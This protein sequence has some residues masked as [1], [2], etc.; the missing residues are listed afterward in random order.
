V[1]RSAQRASG[2][3]VRGGP[4]ASTS[5]PH[6]GVHPA[7]RR[8]PGRRGLLRR[9]L[10]GGQGRWHQDPAA[11]G[12]HPG[13]PR[14]GPGPGPVLDRGGPATRRWSLRIQVT[15]HWR[16]QEA[17]Y[18]K[19]T[20]ADVQAG[21][22]ALAK[23][24]ARAYDTVGIDSFQ[25]LVAPLLIDN[26]TLER[27][28]LESDLAGQMLAGTGKLG[29]V[30]LPTDLRKPLGVTRPLV[31]AKDY[32]GARIGVGEGEV[33]K[34]TVTA[35]GATPV[36]T[37]PGGPLSGLDG[38]DIDLGAIKVNGYDQQATALTANVTLWPRPVTVVINRTVFHSLTA[39]QQA[40]LRQAG[41]AAVARQLDFLRGLNDEDRE[42]LCR[43]GLRFVRASGRDLAGLRRAV[44]PVYDQLEAN[45][46]IRSF[47]QRIRAMKHATAAPPDAPA[48]APSASATATANQQ[49]TALDGVYRT[50]FT[51]K[52][53]GNSPL[54]LDPGEINDQNWGELTLALDRGRVSFELRNELASA[55][56]SGTFTVNGEAIVFTYTSGVEAGG[57]F[58]MRWSLYRDVLTFKR[59]PLPGRGAD[60]V[61]GQAV[62]PGRLSG[63]S[64]R[65][66]VPPPGGLSTFSHPCSASTRSASPRR[67]EPR[68]G[69]ARPT[70]SS[71]ISTA[72]RPARRWTRTQPH[73]RPIAAA[74][75]RH[76]LAD[77]PHRKAAR[78]QPTFHGVEPLITAV[79]LCRAWAA[80]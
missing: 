70:P 35:L 60:A 36:S 37:I 31:K 30:G 80:V 50:S 61:P 3:R 16:D 18:D 72:T 55:K 29:L 9:R 75:L 42:L 1:L 53:L 20:I 66:Y 10:G 63:H 59:D 52:E 26:P 27:R 74:A 51:R 11:G 64:A 8:R 49:A 2:P 54:L 58:A 33:A 32:R 43:R 19:A 69:S 79:G 73:Q 25:A 7:G 71:E 67:P 68:P 6:P 17:D 22:V 38:L 45:A 44:Q 15:N 57:T 77:L 41:T 48:C 78:S 65:R 47:L 28:V 5:V 40:A 39:A 14:A 56:S 46:E 62:A 4:D 12:A 24:N 13:R 76:E 34:A 23:V 21:K